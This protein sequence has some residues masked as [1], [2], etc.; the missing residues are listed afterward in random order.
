MNKKVEINPLKFLHENDG[1]LLELLE[2]IDKNVLILSIKG[3]K[4]HVT[5]SLT[6]A[7]LLLIVEF[8]KLRGVE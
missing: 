4:Q 5:T 7:D 3:N 6:K 2:A 1:T 8:F